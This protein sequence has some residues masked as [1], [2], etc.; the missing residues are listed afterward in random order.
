MQGHSITRYFRQSNPFFH[1]IS[2]AE[3]HYRLCKMSSLPCRSFPA[4]PA[5]AKIVYFVNELQMFCEH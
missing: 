4:A 2:S 3:S 5:D 1:Y